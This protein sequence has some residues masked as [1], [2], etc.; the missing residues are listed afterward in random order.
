M[1]KLLTINNST[2]GVILPDD[3]INKEE[4]DLQ[5]DLNP[6][7]WEK[8]FGFLKNTDLKNMG[9]GRYELD[10]YDL[11]ASIDEYTTKDEKDARYESH[12]LYADIQYVIS[13]EER[14]GIV[15]LEKT[16]VTI[17]YDGEKDI[18]FLDSET[19][20][21]HKADPSR[22][23]IFFPNDA[24]KPCVRSGNNAPVRKVIIKVRIG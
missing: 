4:F 13:G 19:D 1:N 16:V 3:S 6:E 9:K 24:H 20:L 2:V 17:P 8:A 18:C 12:C 14:I 7:R 23:F 15:P 21:L 22:Y 11:F 10:G 5:Y